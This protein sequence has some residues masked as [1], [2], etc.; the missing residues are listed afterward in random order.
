MYS[1]LIFVLTILVL[2]G[3]H[4]L[5]HFVAA[6]L[7]GVKVLRFSIGFGK[8]MIRWKG[9]QTEYVIGWLPLGGYV[10]LLNSREEQVPLE[11]LDQAY[12][13]QSVGR[14]A[15]I[16]FAGPF[17]NLIF[18]ILAFYFTYTL[19]IETVKPVI[20]GILP[21]SIAS[22]AQLK[23]NLEITSIE[24]NLV[25]SWN[26]VALNLLLKLGDKDTLTLTAK[27]FPQEGTT[28][29]YSLNLNNWKI[30]PLQPDLLKSLGIVPFKPAQPAK[31]GSLEE[32]GPA[33]K[34]GLLAGDEVISFNDKPVKDWIDLVRKI[35]AEP[36]TTVS[37]K[38]KRLQAEK[39]DQILEYKI[40]IESRYSF[41]QF[42]TIGY[43]GI[44]P[45][46]EKWPAGMKYELQY[47][48]INAV[49]PALAET[50][51]IFKLNAITLGKMIIG[52]ISLKTLGGP[53]TIFQ[54]AN[55]A[56]KQGFVIFLSFLGVVSVMLAFVNLL[57]IPGLDGGQLLYLVIEKIRGKPLTVQLELLMIRLGIIAL[58]ILTIHV[59]I[60]DLMRLIR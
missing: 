60:N 31:I 16:I 25:R 59:T 13:Y 1:F 40:F 33:L 36:N 48:W 6:K 29:T 38:I 43:V 58:I 45:E 26:D 17:I 11:E 18:A 14:R 28:N 12:D 57:P 52:K 53:L 37:F 3:V 42:K 44:K 51:L 15:F 20:G 50:W 23:P 10:R 56:F 55:F 30:D 22:E 35:W 34:V 46:L 32:G 21:A 49:V 39:P 47:S 4:E 2:V 5:G 41:K 8:P 19:G 24:K 27:N 7:M 9:K 54:A